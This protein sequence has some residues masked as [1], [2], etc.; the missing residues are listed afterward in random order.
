MKI[1]D[2]KQNEWDLLAASEQDIGKQI[3][4]PFEQ[5][6]WD[7][8]AREII[9]KLELN[10]KSLSLLDVGCGNAYLA[11][12]FQK[13]VSSITGIDY[14]PSMIG[15]ARK[16]IPQGHFEVS[17]A[18]QLPFSDAMFDRSLSYSIF[19]YFSSNQ[20]V[21][22]A[23]D[24]LCRVT[25]KGGVILIGDLLDKS[26]EDEIKSGSNMDIEVNLPKIKRYSE[27]RF[28]DLEAVVDY[29]QDK[30][31]KVEILLQNESFATGSYRKDIK[32]WM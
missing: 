1:N 25:K 22:D 26:F 15:E 29:L 3:L 23:I 2:T 11:S 8:L 13:L 27:W 5:S 14:A 31:I 32:I 21:Y 30:A 16:K 7:L 17:S 24:E 4:R 19:H 9:Q 6:Q 28:V 20:Q 18:D 10:D 12:L